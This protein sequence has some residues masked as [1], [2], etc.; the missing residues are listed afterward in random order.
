MSLSLISLLPLLFFFLFLIPF[1]FLPLFPPGLTPPTAPLP[2]ASEVMCP[3]GIKVSQS[4]PVSLP[5][6]EP[7]TNYNIDP[8]LS[9]NRLFISPS[10][11]FSS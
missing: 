11:H 2:A 3:K 9:P 4:S 6:M 8:S 5:H 10:N 1:R 7:Q